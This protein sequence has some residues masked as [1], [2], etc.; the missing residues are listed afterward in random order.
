MKELGGG[1]DRVQC[2]YY[3]TAQTVPMTARGVWGL[4]C[5]ELYMPLIVVHPRG[6]VPAGT[7]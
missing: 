7:P 5:V 2:T 3:A 4:V 6:T 1:G